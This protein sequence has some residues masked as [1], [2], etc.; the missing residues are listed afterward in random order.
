MLFDAWG[1]LQTQGLA[2]LSVMALIGILLSAGRYYYYAKELKQMRDTIAALG[3]AAL[4]KDGA[5]VFDA[6]TLEELRVRV[7]AVRNEISAH[8]QRAETH[9]SDVEHIASTDH[10]K[11]CDISKCI[12]MQQIF[13]KLDKVSERFDQ[14]D[15]RADDSRNTTVVSL[16][17]IKAGQKDLGRE[18]GDL[19]KTILSVLAESLK[20]RGR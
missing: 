13:H 5:P 17:S 19:A 11:N 3:K 4:T 20:N 10:W 9:Y 12:H 1:W 16:E 14:F 15:R 18:L 7:D 8:N 2:V 6:K